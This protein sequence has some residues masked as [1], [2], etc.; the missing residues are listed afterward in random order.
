MTGPGTGLTQRE[1]ENALEF[2]KAMLRQW[3]LESLLPAVQYMLIQGDPAD[4]VPIKLRT[5][6]EYSK[7]FYGNVVREQ[8]GLPAL[9]EAEYLSTEAAMR[10]VV[11][12]NLGSGAYDTADNLSKWIGS[13]VSPQALNDR[14]SSYRK[15][16]E[17]Q[18]QWVKDAWAGHG[19]TPQQAIQAMIDPA[20]SESTLSRKLTSFSL[21]SEALQA[22]K[23]TYD[24]NVDRLDRL[25]NAGVD[26][27]EA[28]QGFQNVAARGEYESFLARSA[29]T[30]LS[31][32]EQEDAEL[33]GDAQVEKKRK[34]VLATDQARYGEN[35]LGSQSSM[36]RNTAGSY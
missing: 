22:Y 3:N 6:E 9:S 16:Y 29:G 5:T 17:V 24:F 23:D 18:P 19:L 7:R 8:A 14:M 4:V 12:R 15:N 2:M 35:Y 20:V 33:L 28:R 32:E 26:A 11:V 25:V 36:G 21:G 30:S 31:R 10:E 13:N 27:D 34:Q 1:Q